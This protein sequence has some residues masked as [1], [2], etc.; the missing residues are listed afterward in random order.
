MPRIRPHW[1]G[2]PS[3][4]WEG[5]GEGLRSLEEERPLNRDRYRDPTS[6]RRGEVN[7]LADKRFTPKVFRFYLRAHHVRRVQVS[8]LTAP[9]GTRPEI[10]ARTCS[11]VCRACASIAGGVSPPICGVAIT[12]GKAAIAG[13]GIWSGARPT[14]SAAPAI[15]P[16]L[17]A[18]ASAASSTRLPRETLMNTASRRILAKASALIRFSVVSFATAR[19]TT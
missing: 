13:V 3:P 10:N 6:P 18:A 19:Q 11:T 8:V 5:R 1:R 17:I 16:S 2:A 12:L 15:F 9:S 7:H 4:F 14:S